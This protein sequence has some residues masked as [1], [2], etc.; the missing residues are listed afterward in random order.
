MQL[1]YSIEEMLLQSPTLVVYRARGRNGFRYAISRF[2]YTKSILLNLKEAC[3]ESALRE[4]KR[5]T[6][7][8]LR[9][10]IDG[11]LDEIDGMP[12]VAR[13]WWDGDYLDD[14]IEKGMMN[15]S[16]IQRL[17]DHGHA[18][19]DALGDRAAAV[20]FKARDV[21]L[22]TGR[23]GQPVET[24]NIDVKNWFRDW[25]MGMAPGAGRNP[26][27]DLHNLLKEAEMSQ[28]SRV[29]PPEQSGYGH[30]QL[31][32][33][34]PPPTQVMVAPPPITQ[35]LIPATAPSGPN[36]PGGLQFRPPIPAP[37]PSGPLMPFPY[38]S[39]PTPPAPA[40][41]GPLMPG[42]SPVQFSP[43]SPYPSG[44]LI[45]EPTPSQM[46]VQGPHQGHSAENSTGP[47]IVNKLIVQQSALPRRRLQFR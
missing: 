1:D 23:G 10:V 3:F 43:P 20:S 11:G 7:G 29:V 47:M 26:Y 12:W 34:M 38:A 14:R 25:A 30:Q 5:L 13:V 24:F 8:C 41:S 15:G 35:P 4:L 27:S 39:G 40:P 18:L 36:G 28:R 32:I 44:A 6:H 46:L 33:P 17:A 9:P 16:D 42:L 37:A 19:I 2:I 31:A 22:T 45:P 21:I